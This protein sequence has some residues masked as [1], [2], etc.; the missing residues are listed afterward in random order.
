M[1]NIKEY[2]QEKE[3]IYIYS[4]NGERY[5]RINM[6]TGEMFGQTGRKLT[7]PKQ[8]TKTLN[9]YLRSDYLPLTLALAVGACELCS[10]VLYPEEADT[11]SL[12]DSLT[13]FYSIVGEEATNMRVS[14][15]RN[16]VTNLTDFAPYTKH[17]KEVWELTDKKYSNP[18]IST[19][20]NNW[21]NEMNKYIRGCLIFG[22]SAE[23][24]KNLMPEEY[25]DSFNCFAA[26]LRLTHLSKEE[27]DAILYYGV[28]QK[29]FAPVLV[30]TCLINYLADYISH[31]RDM[32]KKPAKTASF[33]REFVETHQAWLILKTEIDK[34]KIVKNYARRAKFWDFSYGDFIVKIPTC[35]ED[36]VKEGQLMHHCVGSYVNKIVD[37][38]TYIC[39][40]RHKDNPD[41]EYITCQIDPKTGK[42]GQYYLAYDRLISLKKDI[43]FRKAYQ[44]YLFNCHEEYKTKELA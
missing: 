44:E 12:S 6:N 33:T 1:K 34:K 42:I 36:L 15:L 30:N 4:G 2:Y 27:T 43:E 32:D 29:I 7:S 14:S 41:K 11:K 13:T 17:F 40:I 38:S 20:F 3:N 22:C 39:F 28:K 18:S 21:F 9:S 37:G 19:K 25:H 23:D 26:K 24:I 5:Y 35:G 31:C 8:I 10:L 16:R